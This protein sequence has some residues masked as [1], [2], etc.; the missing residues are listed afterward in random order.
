MGVFG[1]L[2]VRSIHQRQVAHIRVKR[3]DRDLMRML[4]AQIIIHISSTV[5]YSAD[6]LYGIATFY[7]VNKSTERVAIETFFYVLTELIIQL[8]YVA[9]FY[10]FI[11]ASKSFRR[12]FMKIVATLWYKYLL[13]GQVRVAPISN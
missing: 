10:L 5:P 6:M 2:A 1:S 7:V 4:V 9:P 13:R 11:I 12:D 8:I 3:T